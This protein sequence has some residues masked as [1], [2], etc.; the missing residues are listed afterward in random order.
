MVDGTPPKPLKNS[1][2]KP[3]NSGSYHVQVAMEPCC[4]RF[5]RMARDAPIWRGNDPPT[6]LDE[7]TSAIGWSPWPRRSDPLFRLFSSVFAPSA[8]SLCFQNDAT[9]R[10]ARAVVGCSP[11]QV[12]PTFFV[13]ASPALALHSTCRACVLVPALPASFPSL[14]V[15]SSFI[16]DNTMH[17]Q[18][19]THMHRDDV[20]HAR[21]CM[22]AACCPLHFCIHDP[23]LAGA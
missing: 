19:T 6:F 16:S 2:R 5:A 15:F 12:W 18:R 17:K 13:P 11:W 21:Q 1:A 3:E 10:P 20:A 23:R 4:T 22:R 14:R 7:P 9:A 8:L